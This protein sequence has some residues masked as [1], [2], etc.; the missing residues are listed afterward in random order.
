MLGLRFLA[1]VLPRVLL[2]VALAAAV[3][4]ALVRFEILDAPLRRLAEDIGLMS[5]ETRSSSQIVL[6]ELRE[7]YALDTVEYIYRTVFP[8]DYMPDT[9]DLA[10]IMN[11]LRYT[12]GPIDEVLSEDQQLYF[13]AVNL[14]EDVG[15]G[16]QEFMVLTV[17]I[18]AGLDRAGTPFAAEVDTDEESGHRHARVRIPPATVTDILIED[19][20]PAGYPYP[21]VGLD[22]EGWRSVAAFVTEHIEDRTIEEGILEDARENA[23]ALVR[24]LLLSAGIDQVSFEKEAKRSAN[25]DERR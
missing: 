3:F 6:E 18:S 4:I 17:R 22:A 9:T 1:G 14:A 16:E 13:G 7:V 23:R 2:P 10:D 15:L 11:T 12:S 25:S 20:D 8:F 5:R 24:T 21:D 19:V